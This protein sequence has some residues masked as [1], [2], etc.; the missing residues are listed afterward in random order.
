VRRHLS[1]CARD[2]I[3]TKARTDVTPPRDVE[4]S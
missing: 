1:Y 2:D 3:M 4:G